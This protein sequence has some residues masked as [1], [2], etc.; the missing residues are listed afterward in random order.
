[1]RWERLGEVVDEKVVVELGE[2]VQVFF[3][4]SARD[5][6]D[7]MGKLVTWQWASGAGHSLDTD[8]PIEPTSRPDR[9]TIRRQSSVPRPRSFRSLQPP[10]DLQ[11]LSIPHNHP[12]PITTK[13]TDVDLSL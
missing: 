4:R 1:V 13:I 3:C 9:L 5:Q 2:D 10:L 7:S 8:T 11:S 6:R 12:D